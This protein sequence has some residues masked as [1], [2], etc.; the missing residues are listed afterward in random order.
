MEMPQTGNDYHWQDRF[1]DN[2]VPGKEKEIVSSGTGIE[3][4]MPSDTQAGKAGKDHQIQ[5]ESVQ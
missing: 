3:S 4:Q 1:R 2:M 5:T